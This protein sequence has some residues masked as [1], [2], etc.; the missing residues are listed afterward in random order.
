MHQELVLKGPAHAVQVVEVGDRGPA[1]IDAGA[2]RVDQRL[3]QLG[4]L[5]ARQPP[6]GS[7]RMDAGA[8][9]RL[10]GDVATP[11]IFR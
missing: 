4:V 7:K 10:V 6:R 9:K 8:I 2:K 1:R 11:A 3:T 5:G